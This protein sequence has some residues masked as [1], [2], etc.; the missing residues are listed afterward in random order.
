MTHEGETDKGVEGCSAHVASNVVE[1]GRRSF[2]G[3]MLGI[4]SLLIGA[5]VGTPLLRYVLYPVYAKSSTKEWSD[6]GDVSE[7]AGADAPVSRTVTFA[8]R[9]GWREVVS[10][11]SVYVNRMAGGQ[12]QVL[13]AI[14]PHLG[15]SVAWKASEGKFVCPCHGGQFKA[16][17]LHISGPPPRSLDNLKAQVKNGKLQVQF[18]F[19]R[20]NVPD[21]E[22]VS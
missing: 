19:F 20:S 8:Q 13:S 17:G 22:T 15:C 16:D 12:L 7:F 1:I 21:Q 2:I 14:C 5:I 9:D 11:Q 6:V 10:T 18:E 3:A 4:G